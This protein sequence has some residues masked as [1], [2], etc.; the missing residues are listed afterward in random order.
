MGP[1]WFLDKVIIKHEATGKQYFFLCGKW[2]D[3]SEDD[4]AIE[5]EIAASDA[6]GVAC[7]PSTYYKVTAITGDRRGAGTGIII[8]HSSCIIH[9]HPDHLIS[10]C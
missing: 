5:R 3:K 2:F 9:H 4:G 6:D 7:L 10:P 1:G 8:H